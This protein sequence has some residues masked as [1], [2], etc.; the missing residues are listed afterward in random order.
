M[1]LNSFYLT[2]ERT[3]CLTETWHQEYDT[4]SIKRLRSEGFQ[5]LERAQ[6]IPPDD[7]LDGIGY[8]NHGGIAII[9]ATNIRLA[10]LQIGFEPSTF[11]HLRVRINSRGIV[12][13]LSSMDR[14]L[15]TSLSSSSKSFQ[16]Y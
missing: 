9:A 15:S 12:L 11:E 6:P 3:S 10:K 4:V 14:D 2:P 8:T 13:L 5:V 1:R 16:N 7:S